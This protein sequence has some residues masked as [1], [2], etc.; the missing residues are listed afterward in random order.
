MQ[1]G[2]RN[3]KLRKR[4]LFFPDDTGSFL[5]AIGFRR[6]L[7]TRETIMD[8]AFVPH[9]AIAALL[10]D[11]SLEVTTKD[12]IALAQT[13]PMLRKPSAVFLPWLPHDTP[14]ARVGAAVCLRTAGFE[15]VVHVSARQLKDRESFATLLTEL[16]ARADVKRLLLVGGDRAN[17]AGPFATV[18]QIIESGLLEA[19]GIRKVGIAGHPEGHPAVD[20]AILWQALQEKC[21]ALAQRG[22]ESEIVTQFSFDADGVLAWL[23]ELRDRG[24]AI[25]VAIGIPGPASIR[26]LLRYAGRCGVGASAGVVAKYGFSLTKLIGKAGPEPFLHKLARGLAPERTGSVRAHLYPFGGFEETMT[27]LRNALP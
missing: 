1:D 22:I 21:D 24:L 26:T 17:A 5:L 7:E 16:S 2:S 10:S 15:P 20:T 25:P 23:A 12:A 6:M 14:E 18:L 4:L 27:W 13:T 9:A 11:Y 19:A 8:G 3:S